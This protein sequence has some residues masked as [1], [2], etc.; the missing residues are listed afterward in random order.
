MTASSTAPADVV[1]DTLQGYASRGVFRGLSRGRTRGAKTLYR[2]TWH[3]GHTFNLLVDQS[4]RTLRFP[5]LLT[6]VPDDDGVYTAFLAFLRSR[7][8]QALPDHRRIDA[9]KAR[10]R[11]YRRKGNVSLTLEVA[12][13]DYEYGTRKLVHLVQE[14]FLDFLREGPGHAY[15]VETFDLG[16]DAVS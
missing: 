9:A 10:V 6:D 14:I 16:P 1:G 12:D 2:L 3:Y 8:S 11:S 15:L 7:R 5:S 13:G 4:R